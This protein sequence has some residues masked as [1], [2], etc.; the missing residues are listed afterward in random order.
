M[1]KLLIIMEC[2]SGIKLRDILLD[3]G[4]WWRFFL[5]HHQLIRPSI[6]S[7]VL[8]ILVCRTSFLGYNLFICQK[9]LKSIKTPHSCKSRF[10]SS[11]G[12]KATDNWIKTAFNTLPKTKWQQITLTMPD[13]LWDFF[14][15]NRY[16]MGEVPKI[17]PAIIKQLAE[18]DGFLPGIFLA[19]HTFGRD[20]KRNFHIHLST[21]IGGLCLP[22]CDSY[23]E[24]AYFH[25]QTVKNMWRYRVINLLRAE[26]KEG[27]LKLPRKLKHLKTDSAFR[28][29]TGQF[30][31]SDWVVELGQ[32]SKNMKVNVDYLGKYL[33]RPPIGETRIKHYDGRSVTFEYLDHY[34]DTKQTLCLP[35]LDF[36]ARLVSHI[37]DK[38]FRNI[39]YYGF[40]SNRTRGKLLPKVYQ[41]LAMKKVIAKKVYINWRQMMLNMFQRDPLK[42]PLCKTT[43]ELGNIV[44]PLPI[45]LTDVHKKIAH[46][47]YPLL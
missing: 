30:Y 42:C 22:H 35:V 21:T 14:W 36:I 9:C 43:M 11:C 39:R 27:K 44:F 20:L 31:H 6:I 33:K 37:P 10:C 45:L 23:V 24:A 8:K 25:H 7:N 47:Y 18:K 41:F 2:V 15:L 46:G 3:N 29:W 1:I 12:K 13:K 34:T 40:L 4:K 5:K 19:I 28:S 32:Q 17:A 38:H 26:F 16:L